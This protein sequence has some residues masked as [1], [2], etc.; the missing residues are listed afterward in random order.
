MPADSHGRVLK[1]R[2]K[3]PVPVARNGQVDTSTDGSRYSMAAAICLPAT[4][5]HARPTRPN[6]GERRQAARDAERPAGST[7]PSGPPVS[8]TQP[9]RKP[10]ETMSPREQRSAKASLPGHCRFPVITANPAGRPARPGAAPRPPAADETARRRAS[11]SARHFPRNARG[12][13]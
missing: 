12:K 9:G 6:P 5:R 4:H 8:N 13:P 10:A 11:G 1:V 2:P 3:L 7:A